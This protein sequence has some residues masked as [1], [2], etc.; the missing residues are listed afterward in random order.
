MYTAS[1]RLMRPKTAQI[2][3]ISYTG[4]PQI[5]QLINSLMKFVCSLIHE[6]YMKIILKILL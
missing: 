4:G 6:H 3:L 2:V 5:L 1:A